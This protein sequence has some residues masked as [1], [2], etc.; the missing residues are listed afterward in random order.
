MRTGKTDEGR[1]GRFSTDASNTHLKR[2]DAE[3]SCDEDVGVR[4]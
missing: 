1:M 4:Q 2:G 3:F